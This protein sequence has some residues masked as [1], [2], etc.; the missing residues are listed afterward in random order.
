M[1]SI[2]CD[3][4]GKTIRETYYTIHINSC[5]TRPQSVNSISALGEALSSATSTYSYI[6][7]QSDTLQLLNSQPMYC[8]DCKKA[9]EKFISTYEG[10]L[11]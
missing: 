8:E 3:R 2:C 4:C 9:I 1:V 6:N 5:S 11:A 10:D 7:T